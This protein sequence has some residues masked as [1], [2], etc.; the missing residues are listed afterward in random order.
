[1]GESTTSPDQDV[2]TGRGFWQNSTKE[3]TISTSEGTHPASRRGQ[4][5]SRDLDDRHP[6]E[7]EVE[8][9]RLAA[10]RRYDILDTPRDGAFDRI[11]ELASSLFGV[12][13][14][15]VSI[16]DTD[17]IWFKSHHGVEAEETSRDPG[18]CAS[19]ILAD[20]IYV[21]EDAKADPRTL[22]NPLVAGALGLRFYAG[23]PLVTAEG[24]RLGTLC[25]I[26]RQPR[27]L[28]VEEAV[29]LR[30]LAATVMDSLELRLAAIRVVRLEEERRHA[31]E[32]SAEHYRNLAEQLEKGMESSRQIGKAL[33]LMMAQYKLDDV[34]AFEKLNGHSQDLNIKLRQMAHDIVA[35]HNQGNAAVAGTVPKA[36]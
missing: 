8:V 17:R 12:P 9:E 1:V 20:D 2:L 21:V 14:S 18:L 30:T 11:T 23:Q 15:I 19:A 22:A 26:D 3:S 10:V 4:D 5:M 16:V 13:I 25:I 32:A 31:I 34:A 24:Y 28:S 36:G 35:H 33:G 29:T 7:I 6:A 27:Q